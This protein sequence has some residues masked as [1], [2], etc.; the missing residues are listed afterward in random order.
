MDL[1]TEFAA[2]HAVGRLLNGE[3]LRLARADREN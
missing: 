3:W 2:W 1:Y